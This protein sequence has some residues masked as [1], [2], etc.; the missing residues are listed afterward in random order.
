MTGEAVQQKFDRLIQK[1]DQITGFP[2][3][4][5]LTTV[6]IV[7]DPNVSDFCLSI[8]RPRLND[9][10]RLVFSTTLQTFE[11]SKTGNEWLILR[12]KRQRIRKLKLRNV[13]DAFLR[14]KLDVYAS[15]R[16]F[17]EQRSVY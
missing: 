3:G 6:Q 10:I 7:G 4:L 8:T 5:E 9:D 17:S 16:E 14:G 12:R 1:V 13:T 11:A 2:K 15:S